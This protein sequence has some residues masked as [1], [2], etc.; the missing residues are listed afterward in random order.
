MFF[1]TLVWPVW[2]LKDVFS[3]KTTFLSFVWPYYHVST[4]SRIEKDAHW[5][6]AKICPIFSPWTPIW[7]YFMHFLMIPYQNNSRLSWSL[8]NSKH[9]AVSILYLSNRFGLQGVPR[10]GFAIKVVLRYIDMYNI[11][12]NN[13]YIWY[14]VCFWCQL[15]HLW[16]W[17]F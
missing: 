17:V 5:H 4:F 6:F 1:P 12:Q 2:L 10:H 8:Y 7:H 16:I 13:M 9:V 11:T 15:L 3:R 14:N